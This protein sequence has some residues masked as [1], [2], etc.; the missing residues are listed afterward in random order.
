ERL[1]TTAVAFSILRGE[2]HGL[3]D[4]EA[5]RRMNLIVPHVRR[6]ALISKTIDQTK[7]QAATF[8]TAMDA[9]AAG[10]FLLD[11][12]G[13]II[14]VNAAGAA[15][16]D[17]G[18]VKLVNG[19]LRLVEREPDRLLQEAVA[20]AAGDPVELRS[21]A[22]ALPIA[23]SEK[24]KFILHMLPLDRNRRDKLGADREAALLVFVRPLDSTGAAALADF[25][26][27]FGLTK[28]EARVLGALV[29][30]ASV[31]MAADLL[32]IST[33]TARTHVNKIFNKTGAH[34]QA[35]LV[36]LLIEGEYPFKNF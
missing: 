20:A 19:R 4:D 12:V 33:T 6:A 14:H 21:R 5:R 29:D 8:A 27:R 1:P 32:G 26:K 2:Q 34:S 22:A 18:P 16:V 30:T 7:V 9:L 13:R 24:Q 15:M 35:A 17:A 3:I 36:R 25:A 31:P 10:M 11:I 23:A 28:Q